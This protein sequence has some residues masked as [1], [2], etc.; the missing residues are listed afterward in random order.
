MTN[1]R[2]QFWIGI[3]LL[4]GGG[5]VLALGGEKTG[6]IVGTTLGL[7]GLGLVAW[8]LLRGRTGSDP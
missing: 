7:A 3:V 8:V 1:R 4:L 6:T 2:A 5:A